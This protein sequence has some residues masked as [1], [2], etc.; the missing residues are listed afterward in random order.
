MTEYVTRVRSLSDLKDGREVELF[1]QDL[2][3]GPRKYDGEIVKAMV[4]SSPD[5]L[6]GG[7]RLWL[8]SALG[9][10]YDK[11]WAIRITQRLGLAVMGR[12]Y[13]Q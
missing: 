5:R 8:R 3:P 10:P 9:R 11:P 1:I 12:P 7:D 6:P 2:T 4:Y 13:A